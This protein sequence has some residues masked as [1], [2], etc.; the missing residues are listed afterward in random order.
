[1]LVVQAVTCLFVDVNVLVDEVYFLIHEVLIYFGIVCAV[2]SWQLAS[3]QN[4]PDYL[5]FR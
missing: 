4:D 1:M 3:L 2:F 5:K